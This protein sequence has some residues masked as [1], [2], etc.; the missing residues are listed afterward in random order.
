MRR[1]CLPVEDGR[2][3]HGGIEVVP[4]DFFLD[5]DDAP[6][7]RSRRSEAGRLQ[8]PLVVGQLQQVGPAL[9]GPAARAGLG[10]LGAWGARAEH[11]ASTPVNVWSRVWCALMSMAR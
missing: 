1:F 4:D 7:A 6:E 8:H 3:P 2:Q 10:C 5:A 9:A 11:V